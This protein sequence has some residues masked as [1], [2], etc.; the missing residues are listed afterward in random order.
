MSEVITQGT[1]HD[2]K[3]ELFATRY[4]TNG[5]NATDA[6]RAI[7][8]SDNAS[9]LAV[10]GARW[11]K[12]PV[13]LRL[14]EE[15]TE[16]ARM[17]RDEAIR[18]LSEMIRQEDLGPDLKNKLLLSFEKY[19]RSAEEQEREKFQRD[20]AALLSKG[21]LC[22]EFINGD[23]EPFEKEFRPQMVDGRVIFDIKKKN[24]FANAKPNTVRS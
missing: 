17:S 6:A 20:L 11:R 3:A 13:V 4:L 22:E 7:S 10:L 5:G 12:D 9:S 15:S 16:N 1:A 14:I 2:H 23:T 21:D 18:M 24:L 19:T 8:G